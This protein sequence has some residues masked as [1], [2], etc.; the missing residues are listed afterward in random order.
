MKGIVFSEFIEM[1]E[2]VFSIDVADQIMEGSNL[3]SQGAYTSVGTYDHHELI[4]LV[5]RLSEY[6]N[7]SQQDL[8]KTFGNYLLGRFVVLYPS[9]FESVNSTFEFL[10]TIDNHVHIEVRKL[11]ADV[12]LPQFDCTFLDEK[13]MKL[14]YQSE[15]P[16]FSLAHGLILGSI[17]YFNENISVEVEDLSNGKGNKA[18]FI[19]RALG[20]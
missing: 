6:S 19:L 3:K 20:N 17:E 13:T 1:V 15:R 8:I 14:I 5:E 11:Y 10:S 12:E 16:F 18:C 2:D 7:I 4:T 9:F